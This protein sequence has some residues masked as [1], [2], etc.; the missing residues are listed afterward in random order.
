MDLGYLKLAKKE[1]NYIITPPDRTKV[2]NTFTIRCSGFPRVFLALGDHFITECKHIITD[3]ESKL[4][5]PSNREAEQVFNFKMWKNDETHIPMYKFD[6]VPFRLVVCGVD[7]VHSL[8]LNISEDLVDYGETFDVPF[9]SFNDDIPN[10]ISH[11]RGSATLRM[12]NGNVPFS[13]FTS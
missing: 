11:T 9:F 5:F 10:V 7:F 13:V 8:H 2:S 12:W 3:Q 1:L 4:L 6:V